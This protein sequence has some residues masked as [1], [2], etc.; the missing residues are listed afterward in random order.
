MFRLYVYM[1]YGFLKLFIF[2][3]DIFNLFIDYK[4]IF[5][6]YKL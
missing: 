4:E 1:D 6:L 3:K 2:Y 5:E